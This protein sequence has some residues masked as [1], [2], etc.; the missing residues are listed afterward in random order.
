MLGAQPTSGIRSGRVVHRFALDEIAGDPM[1]LEP[2]NEIA[3][4]LVTELPDAPAGGAAVS[5]SQMRKTAVRLLKQERGAG[6][7]A[8]TS[9]AAAFQH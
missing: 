2:S 6:D 4:G 7:G 3:Y 1:L 5:S 9:H 8:A